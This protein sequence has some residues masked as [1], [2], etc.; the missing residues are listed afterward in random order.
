MKPL[1]SYTPFLFARITVLLIVEDIGSIIGFGKTI[2]WQFP[3][4]LLHLY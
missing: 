1:R 4:P 3:Q 2:G